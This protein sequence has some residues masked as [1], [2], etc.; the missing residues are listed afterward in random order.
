MKCLSHGLLG[1]FESIHETCSKRF[2]APNTVK[3]LNSIRPLIEGKNW[4]GKTVVQTHRIMGYSVT[5][6]QCLYPI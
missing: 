2:L 1:R 4:L 5:S 6:R 3:A